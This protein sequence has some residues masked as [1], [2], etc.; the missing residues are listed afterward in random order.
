MTFGTT[1]VYTTNLFLPH[2]EYSP[3]SRKVYGHYCTNVIPLVAATQPARS[4]TKTAALKINQIN[5]NIFC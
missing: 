5:E 1:L 4:I 2:T 3:S